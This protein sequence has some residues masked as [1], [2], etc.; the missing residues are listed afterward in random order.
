[1]A[2]RLSPEDWI[3]AGFAALAQ[4]GLGA[5]RIEALARGLGVSKGSFY[6]H[7]KDLPTLLQMMLTQWEDQ[8]SDWILTS[9]ASSATDPGQRLQRLA[10]RAT[11]AEGWAAEA[12]LRDWA[13]RD[14]VAAGVLA[15]ID[16]RR[17]AYLA[18]CFDAA[19]LPEPMLRARL[20]LQ[21]LVGAQHLAPFDAA[22]ARSQLH[23]LWA[24][25]LQPLPLGGDEGG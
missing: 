12:A 13:R 4:G 2:A 25:L 8:E 20:A 5:V 15:Q 9:A 10:D 24:L 22:A 3:A 21:A 14:P 1:M 6:W 7:F 18:A 23:L 11:A 19:G 17:L 16:R